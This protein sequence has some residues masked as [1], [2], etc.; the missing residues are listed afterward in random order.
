MKTIFITIFEG[1]ESKN[2]LRTPILTTLLK[3]S[4]LCLVLF[5]K[6]G[7]RV[8]YHR[9]EFADPR[10]S[11]EVVE[12]PAV[13]GLDRF[14]MRLRFLLLDT[15]TTDL[16]RKMV[17]DANRKFIMYYLNF[18]ANWL[19]ARK[20]FRKI[21]RYLDFL[22]VKN[23]TYGR[24]FDIYKPD[25]LLCANLFDEPEIHFL[26]EAKKRRVKTIG[27][28]NS[29]DKATARSA[30]RLWPDKFI[31]FND[32]VR[33]DLINY[34]DV[35][36]K[37]I[38]VGGIPQYDQYYS[39]VPQERSEFFKS[40]GISLDKKLI[41]YAAVGGMFGDSD[42]IM[43][44]TLYNLKERGRFGENTE[45]LVRFPPND[46]F[47]EKELAKRPHLKYVYPGV[48]FSKKRGIDWDMGFAELDHLS[49]TLFHMSLLIG[50][51]SS[52]G[53][54]AAFFDRPVIVINYEVR[55]AS[56]A[57]S[58]SLY[59]NMEHYKKAYESG[60]IRMVNS[61][62]DLVLW[63]NKY[64]D[65]PQIDRDGRRKLVETQ[66]KFLDGKSGERIG[67]FILEQ[68]LIA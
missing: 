62:E 48:R 22:L 49:N 50:Y 5:T 26:R 45:I 7:E 40:I 55:K 19:L 47:D 23:K 63:I 3:K 25:L 13:V 18:M 8:E 37:D 60:G 42:W 21:I 15:E 57:K 1:V 17:Y 29:W 14:F 54:D 41:V 16:R 28:I 9:K 35:N 36:K 44:D 64:L 53:V 2:I 32:F 46:F 39:F 56:M 58:P 11:Y 68:L 27:L 30:I 12:N 67:S 65:N 51:A 59:N 6:S 34:H 4:D 24:F 61:E 43:I 33:D 52:I 31:V 10:I 38:F 66:G 20:Y